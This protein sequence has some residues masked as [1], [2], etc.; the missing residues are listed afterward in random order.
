M[1]DRSSGR[2]LLTHGAANFPTKPT[3]SGT[4]A[5]E[6]QAFKLNAAATQCAQTRRLVTGATNQTVRLGPIII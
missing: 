3:H 5:S 4:M 1:G 6:E 2:L